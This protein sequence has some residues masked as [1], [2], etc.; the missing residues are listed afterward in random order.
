MLSLIQTRRRPSLRQIF[1]SPQAW[2]RGSPEWP[3]RRL[4][5]KAVLAWEST[6]ERRPRTTNILPTMSNP[7]NRCLRRLL[8]PIPRFGPAGAAG[9]E[10][11]VV[12]RFQAGRRNHA[13]VSPAHGIPVPA[14]VP[15]PI[16]PGPSR[17]PTMTRDTGHGP[18][19]ADHP[20]PHTPT[21][22]PTPPTPQRENVPDTID[23]V[24]PP[25]GR[26]KIQ[27]LPT[28]TLQSA[29]RVHANNDPRRCTTSSRRMRDEMSCGCNCRTL[30]FAPQH[31]YD[32]ST[33]IREPEQPG[34]DPATPH[35][36][37]QN[38]SRA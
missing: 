22:P 8:G 26:G 38:R 19:M 1:S 3:S 17:K 9:T 4:D 21:P 7:L 28:R 27:A 13:P 23:P 29:V 5:P 32:P 16:H 20:T 6:I 14:D 18:P 15:Q 24:Y 35:R 11:T 2:S 34:F 36:P 31:H 25:P 37:Q 10:A 12:R 33:A 30:N